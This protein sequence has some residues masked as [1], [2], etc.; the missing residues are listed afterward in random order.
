[1][2]APNPLPLQTAEAKL[3]RHSF[4]LKLPFWGKIMLFVVEVFLKDSAVSMTPRK[5]T[6][7]NEY[8]DFL[9]ELKSIRETALDR[10]S[11]P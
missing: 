9:G 5:P 3:F 2:R 6:I 10:E 7:S 1:V 4:M 11:G 8:L